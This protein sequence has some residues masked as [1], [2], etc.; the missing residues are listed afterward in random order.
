MVKARTVLTGVTANIGSRSVPNYDTLLYVA[1]ER[2]ISVIIVQKLYTT[3]TKEGKQFTKHYPRYK[4]YIPVDN[5][6]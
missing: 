2:K 4:T 1:N 6:A 5:W 3:I